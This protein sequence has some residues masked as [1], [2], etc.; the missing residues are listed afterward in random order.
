MLKK[1]LRER[2]YSPPT[3]IKAVLGQ[4]IKGCKMAMNNTALLIKENHDLHA[5]YKKHL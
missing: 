5:A 2:I 3:P 4:I 1:L